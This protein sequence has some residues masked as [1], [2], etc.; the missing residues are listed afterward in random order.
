MAE[1]LDLAVQKMQAGEHALVTVQPAYGYGGAEHKAPLAVIPP[2]STL[3]YDI[4]LNSFVNVSRT[5]SEL[6]M[7]V[8]S[9]TR[10]CP[11]AVTQCPDHI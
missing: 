5:C 2:G 11:H 3:V 6:Q 1:G 4:F 8:I 10:C 7:R 9:C